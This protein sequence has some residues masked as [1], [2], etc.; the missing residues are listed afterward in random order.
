MNYTRHPIS[1]YS[2]NSRPWSSRIY[3]DLLN[4]LHGISTTDLCSAKI[5]TLPANCKMFPKRRLSSTLYSIYVH[6]SV[7][8][9]IGS[10]LYVATIVFPVI[11]E[12]LELFKSLEQVLNLEEY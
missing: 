3:F 1:L 12:E 5:K 8:L 6:I 10:I 4:A 2:N 11:F 9:P 7:K